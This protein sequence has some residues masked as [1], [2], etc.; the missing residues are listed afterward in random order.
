MTLPQTPEANDVLGNTILD[1]GSHGELVI[2]EPAPG[3][4]APPSIWLIRLRMIS[5]RPS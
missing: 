2:T 1:L 5:G 4:T 3:G